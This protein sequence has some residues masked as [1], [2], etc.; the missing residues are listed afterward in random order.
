M[1]NGGKEE[2]VGE[3]RPVRKQREQGEQGEEG[4]KGGQQGPCHRQPQRQGGQSEPTGSVFNL[5]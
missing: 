5:I 1:G 4:R 2:A 3:G